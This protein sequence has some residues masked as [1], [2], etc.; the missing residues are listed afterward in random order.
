MEW[1]AADQA[2]HSALNRSISIRGSLRLSLLLGGVDESHSNVAV[3]FAQ[4][5][6]ADDLGV[7]R[8]SCVLRAGF[9]LPFFLLS[10]KYFGC[11]R[12]KELIPP[13]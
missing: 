8:I 13:I 9:L 6:S 2:R 4:Q 1:A 11:A 10:R 12:D 5:D 7:T 3:L